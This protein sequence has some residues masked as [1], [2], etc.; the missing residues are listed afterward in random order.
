MKVR[1]KIL[2]TATELF[3]SQGYNSTGINQIIEEA[4]IAKGSFYYNF[5]SKEE[6]CT[7]FLSNRH[8]YWMEKLRHYVKTDKIEQSPILSAFDFLFKM[9]K[10]ENFRGCSFLNILSEISSE[11][12]S[13]LAVI[14]DHKTGLRNYLTSIIENES[15]NDHIYL[16]FEGALI[17]SQLFKNQ[18]P[19]ER[20]KKIVE[21]LIQ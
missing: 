11:N 15:L 21:S 20:A 19:V 8:E 13:I 16:L 10:K 4:S 2:S 7:T 17:E 3:Q 1:D 5:K 9:N 12:R 14:Q 18:W 6:L